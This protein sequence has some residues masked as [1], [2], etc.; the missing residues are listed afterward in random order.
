MFERI[1]YG[2]LNLIGTAASTDAQ[3]H[4]L[5]EHVAALNDGHERHACAVLIRD[6]AEEAMLC[7]QDRRHFAEEVA[8]VVIMALSASAYLGIDIAAE[9]NRKMQIN[10][11]RPWK[12]GKA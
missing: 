2:V 9:V 5:W 3:N 7:A 1:P 11:E 12:H 8:D 4:G 10:K 6:E